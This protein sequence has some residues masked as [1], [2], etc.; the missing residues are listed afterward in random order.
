MLITRNNNDISLLPYKWKNILNTSFITVN[1]TLSSSV[2]FSNKVI[3]TKE[4]NQIIMLNP[5]ELILMGDSEYPMNNYGID[6]SF[7]PRSRIKELLIKH[8]SFHVI[9]NELNLA[10]PIIQELLPNL[11][12]LLSINQ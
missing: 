7:I 2:I 5:H 4:R 9:S 1:D 3:H 10:Y 6:R 12:T 8:N 11:K